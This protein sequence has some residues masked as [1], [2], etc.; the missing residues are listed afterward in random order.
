MRQERPGV[1]HAVGARRS[2]GR[3]GTRSICRGSHGRMAILRVHRVEREL[4]RRP[5][6][7]P[8]PPP[9]RAPD[10]EGPVSPERHPDRLPAAAPVRRPLERHEIVQHPY[11][12][13]SGERMYYTCN[14]RSRVK[15]SSG[16]LGLCLISDC[17]RRRAREHFYRTAKAAKEI[18]DTRSIRVTQTSRTIRTVA[19]H[20]R[21]IRRAFAVPIVDLAVS[22]L[23]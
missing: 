21:L 5:G 19:S 17:N 2:A 11:L 1:D 10:R 12:H 6:S 13:T 3:R 7:P 23:K 14:V 16:D 20:T 8:H 15:F 18:S 22:L 9:R 4:H